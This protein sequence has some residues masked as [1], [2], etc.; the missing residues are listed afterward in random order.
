MNRVPM[1][2]G[3]AEGGARGTASPEKPG[4]GER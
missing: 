1:P 2:N 3:E 4:R